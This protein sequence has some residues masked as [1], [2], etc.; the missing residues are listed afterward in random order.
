M[1]ME[2]LTRHGIAP[3]ESAVELGKKVSASKNLKLI[4]FMGYSGTASHTHGW[5]ERKK[6][7]KDD[8]A[9]LM[10]SVSAARKSGLPVEIVTGG[11]TGTYNIDAESKGLTEL[12]AGSF[13]FMDTLYRHIGG[14]SDAAVYTDFDPALTVMTTVIS[15]RHPN[16]CTI[17]AGNKSIAS[18]DRRSE[19]ATRKSRSKIR[20]P[21]TES[22]PGRM[23]T[24]ISNWETASNYIRRTWT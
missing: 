14:K 13:V 18:A 4:G 2:D 20:A 6:R 3:G 5:E 22:L 15:K 23:A 12:Q 7:S 8:L 16:Q 1:R 19:G 10:E 9:G 24:G 11:S 21:S 17:D